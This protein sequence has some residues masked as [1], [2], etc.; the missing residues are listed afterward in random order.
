MKK[1][2]TL[3]ALL[4]LTAEVNAVPPVTKYRKNGGLFGYKTVTQ[5]STPSSIVLNCIDPGLTGCRTHGITVVG[6]DDEIS[7]S[8]ENIRTIENKIDERILSGN[9]SSTIVFDNKVVITYWFNLET[10]ELSYTL[11]SIPQARNKGIVF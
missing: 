8:E 4:I 2:S 1:L 9:N 10:D 3:V 6:D 11:Y 5:T 7:L